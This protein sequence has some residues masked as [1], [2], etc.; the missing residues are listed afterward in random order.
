M[1][2]SRQHGSGSMLFRRWIVRGVAALAGLF[3][4]FIMLQHAPVT[5]GE[6]AGAGVCGI[7]MAILIFLMTVEAR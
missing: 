3:Y 6:I 2:L 4:L 7:I 5:H 1:I